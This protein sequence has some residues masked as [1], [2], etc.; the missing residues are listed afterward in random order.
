MVRIIQIQLLFIIFS[1]NSSCQSK[2]DYS[3]LNYFV[4]EF[5]KD[6]SL[7]KREGFE[8]NNKIATSSYA[9]NFKSS[10]LK[11]LNVLIFSSKNNDKGKSD[12]GF[13]IIVYRYSNATDANKQFIELEQIKQ[14]QDESILGK[15][16]DYLVCD[17]NY[18]LRLDAG[19]FYSD[20]LWSNLKTRFIGGIGKNSIKYI[21]CNCGG[22]C[23]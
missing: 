7:Y 4:K 11:S 17:K 15:D 10:N 9:T 1:T 6:Y 22:N 13:K 18:L 3:N 16:W 2:R 19:C 5:S 14:T 23:N 20:S 8:S 21:E 12:L